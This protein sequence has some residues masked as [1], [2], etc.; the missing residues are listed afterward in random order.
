MPDVVS[1]ALVGHCGPDS[2][3]LRRAIE[4]AV[5]H[6]ELMPVNDDRALADAM[7]AGAVLIVN[8]VL[9][10]RFAFAHGLSII[11]HAT[12]AGV[13]S[14]LVSNFADAQQQAEA[15]GALPGIGK[16]SLGQPVTA[17]RLQAAASSASVRT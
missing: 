10:G 6:A 1:F 16:A 11:K 2:G 12:D 17:E 9:D 5:P 8:R 7:E 13:R 15:A 3:S 4:S 14:M